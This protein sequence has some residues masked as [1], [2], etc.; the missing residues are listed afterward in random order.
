[1]V[2]K[3]AYITLSIMCLGLLGLLIF[4]R[5]TDKC[6]A[7][8][9][10]LNTELEAQK[11]L[12]IRCF[13][14]GKL[15]EGQAAFEKLVGDFSQSPNIAGAVDQIAAHCSS[16][17]MHQKAREYYQYILE[18]WPND[19]FAIWAQTGSAMASISLEDKQ[20]ADTAVAS[21]LANF[22][23]HRYIQ[24]AVFS[25][26]AYS[27]W[28]GKYEE[29]KEICQYILAN[30]QDGDFAIWAQMDLA[31][32]YVGLGDDQNAQAEIE[33]LNSD[34]AA[35]PQLN[36]AKFV[37]GQQ[38]YTK[39][40]YAEAMALWE[41][42]MAEE[43]QFSD[44]EFGEAELFMGDCYQRLGQLGKAVEHYQKVAQDYPDYKYAW[45]ALFL[46]GHN[47]QR[48]KQAGSISASEADAK[49]RAAYQTLIQQ[50]PDCKAAK[51][52]Q[53]WLSRN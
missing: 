5:T 8:A 22:S 51:A 30:W 2:K 50:Y 37:V 7:D 28:D 10:Q 42:V 4:V 16:L 33:K 1:M 25:I 41:K 31:A 6:L 9:Q 49:T 38:Y 53:G 14:E 45:H 32:S 29:A 24:K 40:R 52:A 43:P 15:T 27:R 34:F 20:A 19:E 46:A 3:G 35:H 26:A 39:E 36:W 12:A 11:E 48:M 18:N 13:T 47:E 17:K 23:G 21:L 44:D